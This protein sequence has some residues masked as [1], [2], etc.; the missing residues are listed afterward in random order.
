MPENTAGFSARFIIII[1][2]YFRGLYRKN[3]Q[4]RHNF[5]RSQQRV[6]YNRHVYHHIRVATSNRQHCSALARFWN[7]NI[8]SG[9][10]IMCIFFI[11][12]YLKNK[13]VDS[14]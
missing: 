5:L 8:N 2:S 7:L 3:L 11:C 9:P 14:R 4:K 6:Y 12:S 13:R 1:N 10:R